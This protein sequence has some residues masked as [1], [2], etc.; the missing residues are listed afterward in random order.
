MVTLRPHPRTCSASRARIEILG[1]FGAGKSTVAAR[2][3]SNVAEVLAENHEL[4]P[5]WADPHA[6]TVTGYLGYDLA[7]LLQHAYL[8]ARPA[9]KKSLQPALCDW[10]LVSDRLWA[11]MRL[12]NDFQK[13][14]IVH[15]SLLQRVGS[16]IGYLYLQ[17]PQE[18][19]VSRLVRR[20]RSREEVF[21]EQ[22]PTAISALEKLVHTLP[23]ERVL[24][25]SDDVDPF[26]FWQHV[27]RWKDNL[28]D[29]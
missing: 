14:D 18:I 12:G 23:P 8:A 16:P 22:V 28:V 24:T 9:R 11:S 19:I 6:T 29:A 25:V 13:Y 2:L 10:A 17:Q 4:N 5:Y 27:K 26:V 1:V 21:I 15:Q 3:A 7:F 20:G